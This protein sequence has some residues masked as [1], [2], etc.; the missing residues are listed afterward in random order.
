MPRPPDNR[1][2]DCGLKF[3]GGIYMKS[4]KW[5]QNLLIISMS[6]PT[7]IVGFI[8]N[9]PTNSNAHLS[10][11]S[12][13]FLHGMTH[14]PSTNAFSTISALT[15]LYNRGNKSCVFSNK[16]NLSDQIYVIAVSHHMC[17]PKNR[18][19]MT[20]P[21]NRLYCVVSNCVYN[22]YIPT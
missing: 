6:T 17:P 2:R 12:S 8:S 13:C 16:N 3:A 22:S 1:S 18:R 5:N 21:G 19:M 7:T 9:K 14:D 4:G 15:C 11:P 20:R 10:H